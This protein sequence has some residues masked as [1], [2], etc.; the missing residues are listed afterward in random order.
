MNK[1]EAEDRQADA[2]LEVLHDLRDRFDSMTTVEALEFLENIVE[3]LRLAIVR[4]NRR[5]AKK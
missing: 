5:K 3:E 4:K 1:A 2:D